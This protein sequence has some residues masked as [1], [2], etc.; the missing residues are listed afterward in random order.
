[1]KTPEIIK[2]FVISIFL[3]LIVLG[4]A[5]LEGILSF[6]ANIND[7]VLYI[8][9]LV[10]DKIYGDL[11]PSKLKFIMIFT[12]LFYTLIIFLVGI[13]IKLFNKNE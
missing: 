10:A 9:R 5:F 8:P 7:I 13:I 2:L 11:T 1:M 3:G 4:S 6:Y 12:F